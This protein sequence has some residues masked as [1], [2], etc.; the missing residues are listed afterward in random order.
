MTR[1]AAHPSRSADRCTFSKTLFPSLRIGFL[2]VPTDLVDA[3]ARARLAS[4]VHPPVLEQSVLAAFMLRG[5]YQRHLRRMQTAYTERLETLRAALAR[6]GAPLRLRPVHSGLHAVADVEAGDA[7][8][9]ARAAAEHHLEVMPLGA[10]HYGA[11]ACPD[12]LVL[13][14]GAVRPTVISSGVARLARVIEATD[15]TAFR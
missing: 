2:I 1:G 10:Y 15:A 9:V 14:F 6:S 7:E 4:D 11:G 5:H 13:G 3:F 12:A 8:H